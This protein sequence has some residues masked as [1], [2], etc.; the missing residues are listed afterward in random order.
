MN[1]NGDYETQL[2][3]TQSSVNEIAKFKKNKQKHKKIEEKQK[4]LKNGEKNSVIYL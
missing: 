2:N 3:I 1:K 4:L